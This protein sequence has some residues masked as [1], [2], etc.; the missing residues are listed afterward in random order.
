MIRCPVVFAGIRYS[1]QLPGLHS[2]SIKSGFVSALLLMGLR[3]AK[4]TQRNTN[5]QKNIFCGRSTPGSPPAG[6]KLS[7]V[8]FDHLFHYQVNQPYL[9]FVIHSMFSCRL[10]ELLVSIEL[11][12]PIHLHPFPFMNQG[13]SMRSTLQYRYSSGHWTMVQW[14]ARRHTTLAHKITLVSLLIMD[15]CS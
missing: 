6:L 7:R 5:R 1:F 13:P 2:D 15:A 10:V 4:F 14:A 9:S 8:S 3:R 11:Q 12:W